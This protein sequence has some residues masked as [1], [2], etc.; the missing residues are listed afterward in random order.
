MLKYVAPVLI[1]FLFSCGPGHKVSYESARAVETTTVDFG[2]TDLQST[3]AKMVQSLLHFP[4]MVRA[5][6]Q[7]DG[8]PIIFVD[9]IENKT[10]EHLDLEALTDTIRKDLIQSGQYTFV[11]MK[12]VDTIHEQLE[13]Q[14]DGDVVNQDKA[15]KFGK[16]AAA[17]YMIYG[18]ISSIVKRSGRIKDVYYKLTLNLT[19]VESGIIR[20]SEEKEIRK[21]QKR[22]TFGSWEIATHARLKFDQDVFL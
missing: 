1:L 22:K 9:K 21:I 4:P 5:V 20:W 8:L 18:A 14:N 6:E 12:K 2:S 11:D 10:L 17:D 3:A 13:Y 7:H 15:K 16:Q 19:E